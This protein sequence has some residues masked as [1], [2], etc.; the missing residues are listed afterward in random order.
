[1]ESNKSRWAKS[2]SFAAHGIGF[3]TGEILDSLLG[4]E[5][6]FHVE[7]LIFG[8]DQAVGMATEAIHMAI[9]VGSAAI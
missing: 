2:G 3:V 6:P 4:L 5:M 7:E 9:S 8:V 1:M